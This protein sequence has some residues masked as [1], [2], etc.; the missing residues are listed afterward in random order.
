MFTGKFTLFRIIF[1]FV[2]GLSFSAL[3][4]DASTRTVKVNLETLV[5]KAPNIAK[6][7]S[8]ND[9]SVGT[10]KGNFQVTPQG[11][12]SYSIPISVPPGT[13]DIAPLLSIAYNS[14]GSNLPSANGLLGTGFSLQGLTAISRCPSNLAKNGHIHGVDYTDQ[15][16]FCFNGE[17]LVAVKGAYGQDGTEYRSYVDNRT[18]IISYGRQG[19]GPASFKIWTKGGQ[20][21][22]Y[23]NT[24]DSQVKAEGK[25]TV[26][27]WAL[28]RITDVAGN[29]LDMHYFKDESKGEFYPSEIDYTGN[30]KAGLAPYNS[31][32][33]IY[34]NR[35]DVRTWYK[36]GSKEI[37]D[38][39]LK[40]IQV[41]S[42]ST[43]VYDYKFS[44][45][46]SP[47]TYRSRLVSVQECA[48]DGV[49]LKPTAFNWQTNEKGWESAPQFI[50]PTPI[51][52]AG[53]GDL[54]VRFVDLNGTGVPQ[55]VQN[56]GT[57]KGTWIN[58][59][60][61]WQKYDNYVLPQAIVSGGQDMGLQFVSLTGNGLLDIVQ[62]NAATSTAWLNTGSGWQSTS[63]Y[64][65]PSIFVSSGHDLGA[66]IVDL[67]GRGLPNIIQNDGGSNKG[68]WVDNGN[69]WQ[70]M[71]LGARFT[72]LI[73]NGLSGIIQNNGN[74]SGAWINNGN[75]WQS[76]PQY[77]PP[78]P[79]VSSYPGGADLGV[80]LID[81]TGDGLEGMVQKNTGFDGG[82]NEAWINTGNGWQSAS[83]YIPPYPIVNIV[84][85][86]GRL[87]GSDL[88]ARLV[89]FAGN[90]LVGIVQS[91]RLCIGDVLISK[92]SGVWLNNGSGWQNLPEYNPPFDITIGQYGNRGPTTDQG[93]RIV[94]L[95][96]SGL[97][98]VVQNNGTKSG[99]WLNKAKK[100]P[101]YLIGVTDGYG[102]Q[103]KIDY[104]SLSSKKVN[105][106]T[107]EHD[108]KYPNMDWQG[109]MYVVYQTASDMG[110]T[111]AKSKN[112]VLAKN[113]KNSFGDNPLLHVT[114]YHYIGAKFNHLGY[115][116]LGFHQVT[117]KDES[118][119]INVTTTYSQDYNQHT[120]GQ[121][122]NNETRLSNGTLIASTQ[123][124]WDLKTFGSGPS[125]YFITYTKN[126]VNKSFD[127]SGNL[128]S[129]K[130]TNI[131]A[132]DFTNPIL[133]VSTIQDSTG[134]YKT[135]TT[136][137]YHNDTDRWLIGELRASSVMSEAPNK[138]SITRNSTFSYDA[139]TNTGLL[140]G[141][142]VAP[143]D[144]R[145]TLNTN[146]ERDAFGN[147]TKTTVSAKGVQDRIA[148]AVYDPTGRFVVKSTDPL[149]HGT[150][151][152]YDERF[153]KIL[154]ATDPNNLTL[155]N[156]YDSF[157]RLIQTDYPDLTEQTIGYN[158][159]GGPL[160]AVYTVTTQK[161]G[162]PTHVEY[163]D[164]SN[165]RVGE[166]SQGYNGKL[167][168]LTTVYDELG[169]V[170][171]KSLPYY[172]GDPAYYVRFDYDQLGRVVKNIHPDGTATT[173]EYQGLTTITTNAAGQKYIKVA[174]ARDNLIRV[175]DNLGKVTSY[176][177]DASSNL[178][179]VTDSAGN[180]TT[181][182]YDNYGHRIAMNDL[183]KGHWTYQYDSLGQLISQTDAMK[184]ATSFQYDLLGRMIARSD[185]AGTSYWEYDTSQY[186]IGK[187]AKV[188]SIVS[189][190]K[191]KANGAELIKAARENLLSTET[192]YTYDK[193][194][195]PFKTTVKINGQD[196][197][198]LQRYDAWG[199]PDRIA[200]PNGV[201]V[202]NN[203]NSLGYLVETVNYLTGVP[204]WHLN[205][206]DAA[207]HITS[208]TN[209]SGLITKWS[210]D[211]K[212]GFLTDVITTL[213]QNI[214]LQR[215]LL[216]LAEVQKEEKHVYRKSL[217]IKALQN[218]MQNLHYSYDE[219]GNMSER[220]DNVNG[221]IEDF[222][223]DSLN[224]LEQNSI[225]GGSHVNYKY[226][227][228]GNITYKSDVG[229][230][231]YANSSSGPHAVTSITDGPKNSTFEYNAN[232]DQISGVINGVKR[233]ISYTG[234]S[235]PKEIVQGSAVTDFYY[236]ADRDSFMR[237]DK[238][239]GKTTTTL[240]LGNCEI[241][242]INDGQKTI[243][244]QKSY[245]GPNLLYVQ[246]SDSKDST[247]VLLKDNLG[248]VTDIVD[249]YGNIVQ[250]FNYTPFGEQTQTKGDKPSNPITHKGFTG[251][252]EVE[253][254]NLIHMGGR[255]YDPVIGRFLTADPTM[256]APAN[257]Q[258]LNRYS[259]CL[260]NPLRFTDPNGFGIFD[261][262]SDL[263]SGICNV[264]KDVV[265]A[266]CDFA[267]SI[268][269]NRYIVMA[270]EIVA[271]ALTGGWAFVLVPAI[272]AAS[273]IACGGNFGDALLAAGMAL[274]S[275][276]LSGIGN[277]VAQWGEKISGCTGFLGKG[278]IT[279][280]VRGAVN[281]AEGKSF[282]DGFLA[283][284]IEGATSNMISGPSRVKLDQ[285]SIMERAAASGAIGG[286]VAAAT[287]GNFLDGAETA[288]FSKL[289]ADEGQTSSPSNAYARKDD[290][291]NSLTPTGMV[292][293]ERPL[294]GLAGFMYRDPLLH[295][296]HLDI[297]H[298]SAFYLDKSGNL[299]SS[300][301][302]P[303][304]M[305]TSEDQGMLHNDEINRVNEY[306]FS[307]VQTMNSP[308]SYQDLHLPGFEPH[309]YLFLPPRNCQDSIY[310]LAM[311]KGVAY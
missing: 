227:E 268:L 298:E 145:F 310:Q 234:F 86:S 120:V 9:P 45:E 139:N 179:R 202:K 163:F 190:S 260:N 147:I 290:L 216:P 90:G 207:G 128:I 249:V 239:D 118:T 288:A 102:G 43:L 81:L 53:G 188:T 205:N 7:K 84:K 112:K 27:A 178:T 191:S 309:T 170:V 272:S 61:G 270:L 38:Q 132:D 181:Q 304:G 129:T 246:S 175:I 73:G 88:G 183:D 148:S 212:T 311:Q 173:T 157:G 218:Q 99:A 252:E 108:A 49:C 166:T 60:N 12:A 107:K 238:A 110:V 109:P 152:T 245:I 208:E 280:I 37:L 215:E 167:I 158:W 104:E 294:D 201:M 231:H 142:V 159:C 267:K 233:T 41:Y 100:F 115:G 305:G 214:K 40:E 44:Y 28:N 78:H 50:P 97:P 211:P 186:G 283:G 258:D 36:A 34:E 287:G 137:T 302:G 271:G 232:G 199:R 98:G 177:Y 262:V 59:G 94:D 30:T 226:D 269:K 187:L 16:L 192:N 197:T 141:T 276:E 228:L 14:Q 291:K 277:A 240:Y 237:V 174:N 71:P 91:S 297:A 282:K 127:F 4:A 74:I 264:I 17:Q 116:F 307:D 198:S 133:T 46:I 176:D 266:V 135:T 42:R 143:D 23:A 56:N 301:Y 292:I 29:Y 3:N 70:S 210:Y 189:A 265:N 64:L 35:P 169:R 224:R 164:Q 121:S 95:E 230:Y 256:Q 296:L 275:M 6:I 123:N 66:R 195:R 229:V 248:S 303:N 101:D 217:K 289:I 77:I 236:N 62:R 113:A 76:A 52:D 48:G 251:H 193:L 172:D 203:Y 138:P 168:W 219:I 131:T 26:A 257:P 124:T 1:A 54:G 153:G 194:G 11:T 221:V 8:N 130:N 68:A 87:L 136:N 200:Y 20:V 222:S 126:V 156:H 125:T 274:V 286:T 47:N 134:T 242:S 184:Q 255:I 196:Y 180:I 247:Y 150:N 243:V 72:D 295:F 146:Y 111:D 114:T 55:M 67:D 149:G 89:D 85:S 278:T 31:V 15:D 75:G 117:T 39:R 92:Y 96:G 57:L 273:T 140:V 225:E 259:Y 254:F 293:G 151:Q 58:T 220:Q 21:A 105:V 93:T 300:Y 253:A 160:G 171:Q 206:M 209:G 299:Q 284:A 119:G 82:A 285:T 213:G 103:L 235:K 241:A 80:R 2:L 5:D 155:I 19:N 10:L 306:K 244:Q 250:H 281:V 162:S 308:L 165:R 144:A 154:T 69:G 83:Q 24:S 63:Q 79:I 18:K 13:A 106:Y 279:G 261:W 161:S 25:T 32:K 122:L 223:Y 182:T 185:V 204:Y 33:F 22:E 65:S 51:V 263:I